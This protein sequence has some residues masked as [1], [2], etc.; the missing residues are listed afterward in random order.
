[1]YTPATPFLNLF[2]WPCLSGLLPVLHFHVNVMWDSVL[3]APVYLQTVCP[4]FLPPICCHPLQA[5][6]PSLAFVDPA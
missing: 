2:G 6:I 3:D 4:I 5:G 1:M